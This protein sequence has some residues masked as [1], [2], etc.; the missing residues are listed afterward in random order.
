[1]VA[2]DLDGLSARLV[3]DYSGYSVSEEAL[4]QPKWV[5][6]ALLSL[7]LPVTPRGMLL[8]EV[9]LLMPRWPNAL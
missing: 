9:S 6:E 5:H 2:A 3:G 7:L 1:M 4:A 8:D